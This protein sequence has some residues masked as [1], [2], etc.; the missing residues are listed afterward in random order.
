MIVLS[1][2]CHARGRLKNTN[3]RA[4]GRARG[5]SFGEYSYRT[6]TR[7]RI[8][9][10]FGLANCFEKPFVCLHGLRRATGRGLLPPA[11]TTSRRF[12]RMYVRNVREIVMY[13][14]YGRRFS[15][16]FRDKTYCLQ[17]SGESLSTALGKAGCQF[18]K[19]MRRCPKAYRNFH[20]IYPILR[21]HVDVLPPVTTGAAAAGDTPSRP[22]P[23]FC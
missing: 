21:C 23:A 15:N 10:Y 12:F 14:R 9:W 22:F 2:G 19:V 5:S 8:Q 17:K 20:V 11:A 3:R 16:V 7:T 6:R 1:S 18:P 4:G 13:A